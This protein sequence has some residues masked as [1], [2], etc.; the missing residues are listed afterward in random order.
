MLYESCKTLLKSSFFAHLATKKFP[1]AG[2]SAFKDTNSVNPWKALGNE[3]IV[4]APPGFAAS[5]AEILHFPKEKHAFG[6][7]QFY[8]VFS[9]VA[10]HPSAPH[11][12]G[13]EGG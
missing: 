6:T 12:P 2:E 1:S 8:T 7:I 5:G 9:Q 11:R 4:R 10:V 13:L 3:I